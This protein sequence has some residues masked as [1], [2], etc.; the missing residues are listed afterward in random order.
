MTEENVQMLEEMIP[1]SEIPLGRVVASNI[2]ELEPLTDEQRDQI[3]ELFDDMEVAHKHLV[4]SCSALRVLSRLLK[5]KQLILLLKSSV[6]PLIQINTMP[7]WSDEPEQSGQRM[8]LPEDRSKL[9]RLTM[10]PVAAK[11]QTGSQETK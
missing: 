1:P 4:C 5:S 3:G 7:G 6:R 8:D 9:V 11:G 10:T 2:D